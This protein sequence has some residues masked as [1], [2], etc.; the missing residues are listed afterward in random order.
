MFRL[1]LA[2]SSAL[3]LALCAIASYLWMESMVHHNYWDTP[4][5]LHLGSLPA[6]YVT[7]LAAILPSLSG[8]L[9]YRERTIAKSRSGHRGFLVLPLQ[10]R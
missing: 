6:V 10:D 5:I 9:W 1:I 3:S 4:V 2:I 8:W 7:V